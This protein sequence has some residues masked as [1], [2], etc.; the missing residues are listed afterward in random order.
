MRWAPPAHAGGA[1]FLLFVRPRPDHW[2]AIAVPRHWQ[3]SPIWGALAVTTGHRVCETL[4]HIPAGHRLNRTG[5]RIRIGQ[6]PT[7]WFAGP[8]DRRRG[9]LC[10]SASPN[11]GPA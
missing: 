9:T 2:P 5:S 8:P 6:T 7:T 1:D 10:P 11:T 4:R 3:V